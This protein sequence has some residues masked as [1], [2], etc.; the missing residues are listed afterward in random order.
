MLTF[1]V[2]ALGQI[3]V[4]PLGEESSLVASDYTLE[5]TV[6]HLDI[7]ASRMESFQS[8]YIKVERLHI[9]K[10]DPV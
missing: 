5:E 7:S 10:G 1:Q 6:G 4:V 3:V 2:L 8:T 9:D